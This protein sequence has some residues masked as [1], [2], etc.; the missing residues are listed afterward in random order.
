MRSNPN[1]IFE[2]QSDQS[3]DDQT[4]IQ[5]ENHDSIQSQAGEISKKFASLLG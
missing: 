5:I 4:H 3:E 2:T 1:T